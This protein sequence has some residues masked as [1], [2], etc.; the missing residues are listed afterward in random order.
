MIGDALGSPKTLQ[1]PD[2]PPD[3][4]AV[5]SVI[6]DC[7]NELSSKRAPIAHNTRIDQY[8]FAHVPS[9]LQDCELISELLEERLGVEITEVD[10][11]FLIGRNLCSSTEDWEARYAPLFTFGRLAE[12]VAHRVKLGQIQPLT[13]LGA[14]SRAAGAFRVIEQAVREI[15]PHVKPFAPSTPVLDRLRGCKLARLW[16][17]LRVH[18]ANRIPPLPTTAAGRI[19]GSAGGLCGIVICLMLY[20][21]LAWQLGARLGIIG[22]NSTLKWILTFTLP[23]VILFFVSRLVMVVAERWQPREWLLPKGI[24]NFRDLAMLMS[25]DRGGWCE[26]CGYDLTGLV[27]SR[28]PECGK[29]FKRPINPAH[30]A[31]RRESA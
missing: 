10:W 9:D 14:T 15:D 5:L 17:R 20:G 11:D 26:H 24:V 1:N 22:S 13:I 7:V 19:V 3:T 30:P 23:C 21:V 2:L 27:D 4:E 18:S 16:A 25:A 6:E 29:K 28:C 12:L 8:F 31:S